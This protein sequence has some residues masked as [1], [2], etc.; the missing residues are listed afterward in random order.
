MDRLSFTVPG[1][2]VPWQRAGLSGTRHYTDAATRGYAKLVRDTAALAMRGAAP[3]T[4]ACAV[5]VVAYLAIPR[6][7]GLK[8]A[9]MAVSGAEKPKSKPDCDNLAKGALD[10]LGAKPK[11]GKR[12]HAEPGIVWNDDAQVTELRIVKRYSD[13]PRLEVSVV[14][15][16]A[17]ERG[18][19]II[20]TEAA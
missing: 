13:T 14:H 16:E 19:E 4:G 15:L 8:R 9:R 5:S 20:K 6:S 1:E 18:V 12:R 2:P 7:W 11:R 10:A 3:F 17:K